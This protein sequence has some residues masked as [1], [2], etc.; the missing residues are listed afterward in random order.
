MNFEDIETSVD[1]GEPV[2]LYKFI[3]GPK[4]EDFFGYTDAE[5]RLR[6]DDEF[7]RPNTIA[8]DEIT[9]SG[10]TDKTTMEIS[11]TSD[12]PVAEM[13]R[14]YPPGYPVA[15]FIWQGHIGADD[16][17]LQWSGRVLSVA[18]DGQGGASLTCEPASVS[19]QRIGLRRH[20][21]Y[22]CMHPLY[23][24]QCR[25][26]KAAA[27]TVVVP[28]SVSGRQVTL[29]GNLANSAQYAGGIAEWVN[30]DGLT[31]YRTILA[32]D[33]LGGNTRLTLSGLARDIVP[34]TEIRASKGCNRTMSHCGSI[35]N[36]IPNFGG[37]P[38][39][40]TKNPLGRSTPFL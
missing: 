27:T 15:V 12:D 24:A 16:F 19:M 37:F 29:A 21:Q 14:V 1:L 38:Y 2:S 34:G 13:F 3:Y 10:T 35:H 11:V 18:R 17:A 9:T 28:E 31:E 33:D 36:N 22:M 26:D 25:A 6:L 5:Q 4:P 23:G 30:E 7:Y 20:Y 8:R 40:P 32:V 39:I